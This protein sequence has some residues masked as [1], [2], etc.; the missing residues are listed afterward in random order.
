MVATHQ[1]TVEEVETAPL[2]GHWELIDGELVEMTPAGFESSSLGHRIGRIVGNFVDAHRLGRMSGADGGYVLFPDRDTIRI[3]DVAFVREE[4]L[5][6]AEERTRFLRL[7]PDLA[8]EVL[9]P[10]DSASEVVI[11]LEMYREA[12]VPLIWLVDP[13]KATITVIAAGQPGEVL[14]RGDMLDGGDVLPGF[15]VSVADIF[16]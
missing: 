12:A 7:A 10:S 11:K 15:R 16:A 5:P 13:E 3:P 6:P 8:V 4:R 2:E 9:S 1:Y 14:K